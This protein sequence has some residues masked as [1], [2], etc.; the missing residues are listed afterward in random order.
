MKPNTRKVKEKILDRTLNEIKEIKNKSVVDRMRR[1]RSKIYSDKKRYENIL[2]KDRD[3]KK[4]KWIEI[5]KF[6]SLAKS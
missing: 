4:F 2:K 1:Y 6:W 3:R 5:N